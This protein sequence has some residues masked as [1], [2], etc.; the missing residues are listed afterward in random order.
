MPPVRPIFG[1]ISRARNLI[2]EMIVNFHR[3]PEFRSSFTSVS[4]VSGSAADNRAAYITQR[5]QVTIPRDLVARRKEG[6]RKVIGI[7][8]SVK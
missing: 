6:R 2:E 4:S 5:G 3:K 1:S 8:L 7:R